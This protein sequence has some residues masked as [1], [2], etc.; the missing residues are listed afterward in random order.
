MAQGVEDQAA[1]IEDYQ[2]EVLPKFNYQ[3]A[4]AL[5]WWGEDPQASAKAQSQQKRAG[6]HQWRPITTITITITITI[7]NHI[8]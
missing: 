5:M 8:N 6:I 2:I 3:R 7:R 4:E 1:T